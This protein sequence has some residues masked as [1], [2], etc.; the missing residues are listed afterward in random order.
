MRILVTGGSGFIGIPLIKRLVSRG[1][2]I[3]LFDLKP[4]NQA[5]SELT[6]SVEIVQ[7]DV[8]DFE[9][10]S[11]VCQ[12]YR[13]EAVLHLAALI[14]QQ[15]E[16]N[17]R[18]ALD[19]NMMGTVSVFDA[20]TKL[21]GQ[22]PKVVFPSTVATFSSDTPAPIQNDARQQP[23]TV[24][25][26]TKVFCEMW[27]NYCAARYGVDFRSVRLASVIGPGRVDGGA[28]VFASLMIENPAKG[29]PYEVKASPDTAIPV[30]YID[31]AVSAILALFDAKNPSRTVYNSSGITP[32]A[33]EIED[34]VKKRIPNA[35][36]SFKSDPDVVRILKQWQQMDSSTFERDT[37]WRIAYTLDKMVDKFVN[38]AHGN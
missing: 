20:V 23:R 29:L 33:S 2:E 32:K 10:L 18:V 24:Y 9:E 13:P 37:G 12:K 6:G 34:Q 38:S 14:S 28:S 19:V 27:G 25:G 22:R 5:F 26:I 35:K 31:D 4:N 17:P 36:I 3:L 16:A 21:G 8:T 1:D 15:A 7:G 30:I 11:S